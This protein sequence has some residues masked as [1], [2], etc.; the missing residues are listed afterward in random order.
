LILILTLLKFLITENTAAPAETDSI[1]TTRTPTFG[2]QQPSS[3]YSGS[4][5]DSMK[6]TTTEL[7]SSPSDTRQDWT[8]PIPSSVA[9]E[10]FPID[11]VMESLYGEFAL[12]S[13]EP[14]TNDAFSS[15]MTS[16]GYQ[17]TVPTVPPSS[18]PNEQFTIRE[19][20]SVSEE[21]SME[22][23]IFSDGFPSTI[24]VIPPLILTTAQDTSTGL[25]IEHGNLDSASSMASIEGTQF[26]TD[27]QLSTPSAPIGEDVSNTN[28][29]PVSVATTDPP[30][31]K[32]PLPVELSVPESSSK[33]VSP[34]EDPAFSSTLQHASAFD[35]T[36]AYFP[37]E[38][39]STSSRPLVSSTNSPLFS[40]F[41]TELGEQSNDVSTQTPIFENEASEDSMSTLGESENVTPGY[42]NATDQPA[43]SISEISS[44]QG[45]SNEHFTNVDTTPAEISDIESSVVS[46]GLYPTAGIPSILESSTETE[47]HL[48]STS[49]S[50][51]VSTTV[52]PVEPTE[53]NLSSA[54][55]MPYKLEASIIP[56]EIQDLSQY[57]STEIPVGDL[58]SFDAATSGSFSS[59]LFSPTFESTTHVDQESS[60]TFSIPNVM[61]SSTQEQ[62][63]DFSSP[64][65]LTSTE[66][67]DSDN[68]LST[69]TTPPIML[70]ASTMVTKL[71]SDENSILFSTINFSWE[72]SQS[73]ITSPLPD[74]SKIQQSFDGAL[75][76]TENESASP[77]EQ[78]FF[79]TSSYVPSSSVTTD[80][81][82]TS[83]FQ[84]IDTSTEPHDDSPSVS[85]NSP[86]L[87]EFEMGSG[88]E[89]INLPTLLPIFE[90][91]ES[92][93]DPTT[94]VEEAEN[95]TPGFLNATDQPVAIQQSVEKTSPENQDQLFSLS[96][97]DSSNH[98][99]AISAL[100][101]EFAETSPE[102]SGFQPTLLPNLVDIAS[103][104]IIPDIIE[105][106]T[107]R[108]SSSPTGN[109]AVSP[110][111]DN[112]ST[113]VWSVDVS[114]ADSQLVSSEIYQTTSPS[115]V[116]L[117][118][119]ETASS[120]IP[121]VTD[122]NGYGSGDSTPFFDT[123]KPT[124]NE[125]PRE[126]D[127]FS[128]VE[129]DYSTLSY[130]SSEQTATT[131]PSSSSVKAV[132]SVTS[133]FQSIDTS[134][135]LHS[136]STSFSIGLEMGSGDESIDV[137]TEIPIFENEESGED[138]TSTLEAEAATDQP[139]INISKIDSTINPFSSS[140]ADN[141]SE[142]LTR[143][144]VTTTVSIESTSPRAMIDD[145]FVEE[146]EEIS[147]TKVATIISESLSLVSSSPDSSTKIPFLSSTPPT[148][149]DIPS[150]PSTSQS[151]F[152]QSSISLSSQSFTPK[153]DAVSSVAFSD[154]NTITSST[155]AWSG[156]FGSSSASTES[157]SSSST[158]TISI[159]TSN[160]PH[161]DIS[162]DKWVKTS[163]A[164]TEV[165]SATESTT[166]SSSNFT[167][168][169]SASTI[170]HSTSSLSSSVEPASTTVKSHSTTP[171]FQTTK[172]S[173]PHSEIPTTTTDPLS[174]LWNLL[175]SKLNETISFPNSGE[176]SYV[177]SFF[178]SNTT[179][180]NLTSESI[181]EIPAPSISSPSVNT[182]RKY[183]YQQ[184]TLRVTNL[185]FIFRK[186]AFR[187]S[188]ILVV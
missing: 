160:T 117:P 132:S 176:Y 56:T 32:F 41:E 115:I 174:N 18:T 158:S 97:E 177:S 72:I 34:T 92:G 173:L 52:Q 149:S 2:N 74:E 13:E 40:E 170:S 144:T 118:I 84:S 107:E 36:D 10:H 171:P 146:L 8:S 14:Q 76:P 186:L 162:T 121:L 35:S 164:T 122:G 53:N 7:P 86:L 73:E 1:A 67:T 154:A 15:E 153:V 62:L 29:N 167:T 78:D 81:S 42:L 49:D 141:V 133:S 98:Q 129:A 55:S 140:L 168:S 111:D 61:D 127:S 119:K 125:S 39:F 136:A 163:D 22:S 85:T 19:I 101:S 124:E 16:A 120:F 21:I 59:D 159:T 143:Y 63:Q 113:A 169:L 31:E 187:N 83:S 43:T 17:G 179:S 50:S 69:T 100:P 37:T 180:S 60:S 102:G 80:S 44:S 6:E 109:S 175:I 178:W 135:E 103:T 157:T 66:E 68:S 9:F 58:L 138:S 130:V 188:S 155:A 77:R 148:V 90:N 182:G 108:L 38:Q 4:V 99:T 110:Q 70:D 184:L 137:P 94:T 116:D 185:F 46:D 128:S 88:D 150:E 54:S 134:T 5:G 142:S 165:L 24:E 114:A 126:E 123:L 27:F 112:L 105:A 47:L 65:S 151:T 96:P 64:N 172:S 33:P 30:P 20:S 89:S 152:S 91:E 87:S 104:F 51:A 139:T 26:P 161:S 75:K 106:S 28:Y 3:Q 48:S 23:H 57:S 95:V 82:V 156:S 71:V 79:S 147:S 45:Y 181:Q 25:L 183:S 11:N 145:S 166:I 12:T 93:E 131:L